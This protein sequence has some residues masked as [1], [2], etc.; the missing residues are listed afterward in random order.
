MHITQYDE[1]DPR[2]RR[3]GCQSA[4]GFD[5]DISDPDGCAR[6]GLTI[7]DAHL[8]SQGILHGGMIA[9]LLDVAC[10]NTASARFD[11]EAHPP[12]LTLSLNISY[13]AGASGG[14]VTA[15]GRYTGGGRNLAY[16]SGELRAEDGALLATAAGVFK[17][18]T[19][20]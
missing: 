13:V 3:S 2:V 9:T 17:R 15:T 16:V 8:N 4:V 5:V 18:R 7:G 19:D 14:R 1:N 6:A 12:V 10:G 11:R 20:K